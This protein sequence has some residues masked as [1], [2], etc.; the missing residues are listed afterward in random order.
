MSVCS[1]LQ[2][3]VL[4]P[5]STGVAII[6]NSRR[7]FQFGQASVDQMIQYML[8][9]NLIHKIYGIKTF[10]DKKKLCE[11]APTETY[12]C[13]TLKKILPQFQSSGIGKHNMPQAGFNCPFQCEHLSLIFMHWSSFIVLEIEKMGWPRQDLN[14]HPHGRT[15]TCNSQPRLVRCH[16]VSWRSTGELHGR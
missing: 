12:I 1:L 15:R 14:L 2:Y 7:P 11:T 9:L 5:L 6:C 4:L 8:Q 16:Y 13:C 3:F 10:P